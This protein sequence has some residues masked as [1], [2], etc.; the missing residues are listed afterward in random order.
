MEIKQF[1][2]DRKGHFEAFTE[3]EKAGLMTYKWHGKD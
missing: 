1:N 2:E 3:G